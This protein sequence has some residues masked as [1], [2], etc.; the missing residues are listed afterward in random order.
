M[1]IHNSSSDLPNL[2]KNYWTFHRLVLMTRC[3]IVH[4]AIATSG[5]DSNTWPSLNYHIWNNWAANY[6][7]S[8]AIQPRKYRKKIAASCTSGIH[9]G[10]PRVLHRLCV[11]GLCD[12]LHSQ[13]ERSSFGRPS[14]GTP[15]TLPP[16]SLPFL[17][18]LFDSTVAWWTLGSA[19]LCVTCCYD[20]VL[21]SFG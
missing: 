1:V 3:Q 5:D 4:V 17:V 10:S 20:G 8:P 9:S 11:A 21:L 16:N 19:V 2:A 15:R 13:I 18:L 12:F 14:V 6:T 7:C